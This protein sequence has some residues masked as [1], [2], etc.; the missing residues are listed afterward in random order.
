MTGD[1]RCASTDRDRGSS[2]KGPVRSTGGGELSL[3][4]HTFSTLCGVIGVELVGV[5]WS[6]CRAARPI[7]RSTQRVWRDASD[8]RHE[9]SV[10]HW[11]CPKWG[12]ARSVVDAAADPG[13]MALGIMTR[14]ISSVVAVA[15]RSDSY[16][17]STNRRSVSTGLS[18]N[19]A[20]SAS[21][22][23]GV[24]AAGRRGGYA[25]RRGLAAN[26]VWRACGRARPTQVGERVGTAMRDDGASGQGSLLDA[27]G[28]LGDLVEGRT[29]LGHQ[30]PDLLLRVDHGGVVPAAEL[31]PDLG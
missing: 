9:E 10:G 27:L 8:L 17:M 21:P 13:P 3:P 16:G 26:R 30:V 24:S 15:Q 31:L 18:P 29:A 22:T 7:L 6:D 14:S 28:Q 5:I 11:W 4:S 19:C 20:R 2:P 12:L 23:A 25:R 1:G